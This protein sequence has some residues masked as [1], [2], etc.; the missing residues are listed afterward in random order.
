MILVSV[1]DKKASTYAPPLAYEHVSQA[2]RS[3]VMFVRQKPEAIHAQ[4]AED[5]DLYEVGS[6]NQI[7]GA[8]VGLIPPN[9]IESMINVVSQAKK[10]GANG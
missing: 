5:Y 10:E 6:F 8:V 2:L 3:Y 1:F 7:S 4:F 9:Y